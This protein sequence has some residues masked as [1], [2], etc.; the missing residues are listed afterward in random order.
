MKKARLQLLIAGILLCVCADLAQGT[1]SMMAQS[2]VAP[3][4]V[5][6]SPI[7]AT[8]SPSGAAARTQKL[9]MACYPLYGQCTKDSDCCKGFFC[10]VGRVT[11][12][13]DYK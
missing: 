11:A 3:Q 4:P 2:A 13:C 8:T 10:R 12:Y 5:Y 6:Y 7:D 9:R 1:R